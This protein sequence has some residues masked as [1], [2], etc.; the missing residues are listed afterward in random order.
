MK[1]AKDLHWKSSAI[2]GQSCHTGMRRTNCISI[3]TKN[4]KAL[5]INP[6]LTQ[7]NSPHTKIKNKRFV[8]IFYF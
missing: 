7:K 3:R 4:K 2:H 6:F 5:I 1:S 8:H